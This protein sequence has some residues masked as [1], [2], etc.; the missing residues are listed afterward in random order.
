[1]FFIF[2]IYVHIFTC[3]LVAFYIYMAILGI[4]FTYLMQTPL[5]FSSSAPLFPARLH[6]AVFVA[7]GV[8]VA[9]LLGIC[10]VTIALIEFSLV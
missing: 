1:M 3:H 10:T 8:F 9:A 6:E 2:T 7:I 4:L 5:H